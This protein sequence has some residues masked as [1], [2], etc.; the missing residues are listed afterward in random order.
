MKRRRLTIALQVVTV[1]LL[2]VNFAMLLH[3]DG[4]LDGYEACMGAFGG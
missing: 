2:V 1:I 4:W 3:R